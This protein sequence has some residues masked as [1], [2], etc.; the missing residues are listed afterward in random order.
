MRKSICF[1]V[2][3]II[4]HNKGFSHV[5]YYP[6]PTGVYCSCGP[7]TGVGEGSVASAIAEKP[8]VKG[9]LVRVGWNLLEQMENIFNWSLLDTQIARAKSYGKKISLAIGCGPAIP[10]WVDIAG[11]SSIKIIIPD[12][13]T[14]AVP[15]DSVFL[16][17]WSNFILAL[18]SRYK[19]DTTITLVYMTNSTSNGFEM[20]I[21]RTTPPLSSIGY[22]D[23]K[24]FGSW[25]LVID[26]FLPLFRTII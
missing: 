12:S 22:T 16:S 2:L 20:E 9:I 19:N 18:G 4:L 14:I 1:L 7:T 26:A 13:D 5:A 15:W 6:P 25:K 8:F 24:M 21:N 3:I 23:A 11:A 10:Q 17:K